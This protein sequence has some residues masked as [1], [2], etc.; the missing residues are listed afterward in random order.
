MHTE[1]HTHTLAHAHA[2]TH[3]H[4]HTH[5]QLQTHNYTHTRT[6]MTV[7][8]V[9]LGNSLHLISVTIAT[10]ALGLHNLCHNNFFRKIIYL[11]R[12]SFVC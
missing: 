7:L 6:L 10:Q 1:T 9:E 2:H 5:T 11:F 8:C 4:T 12:K 3:T